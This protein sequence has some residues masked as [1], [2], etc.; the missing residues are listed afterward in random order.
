MTGCDDNNNSSDQTN[1]QF[2]YSVLTS[3]SGRGVDLLEEL[4]SSVLPKLKKAGAE[5]YALWSR[6]AEP[7]NSFEQIAEDK[8]VVMLRWKKVKTTRLSEVLDAMTGVSNVTT[9]FWELIVRGGEGPI[10]T[11]TGFYIHRSNRSLSE[12]VDEVIA[13][14]EQAW[15][16]WEPYWGAKT[17]GVWRNL[18]EVDESNGITQLMRIAWYRDMEHWMETREFWREPN[19]FEIFIERAALQLDDETWSADL[20]P[21]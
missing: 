3:V 20:Q 10:E 4:N 8:L 19:S 15:E 12:D 6:P 17:V 11:G 21:N 14:S 13:L 2:S 18:D 16:T 7:N 1:A 5:E 9:T